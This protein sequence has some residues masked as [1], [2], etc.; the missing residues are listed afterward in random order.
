MHKLYDY[1]ENYCEDNRL[2]R[3]NSHKV[4]FITTISLLDKIIR[5][6][7][8]ILDVGAGTGRYSFYFGE[9]GYSVYALEFTPHNLGIIRD[10][11][12]VLEFRD[13]VEAAIGDGRDLSRFA[14]NRFDVVLC[15]GPMYHLHSDED[16]KLCINE[17][18]RVLKKDGILAVA[19]INK[20]A[21]YMYNVRLNKSFIKETS[22]KRIIELGCL[23][24]DGSDNF[25]FTSPQEMESMLSSFAI[26]FVVH[27]AADGVGHILKDIIDGLDEEEYQYWI[28]HH[29]A[30]CEEPSLLGY[31]LHGLLV[32]QK[33]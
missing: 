15:M 3:D 30:T 8:K 17:C 26:E 22:S 23:N 29:L 2:I 12:K 11:L 4:E 10:K 5:P 31:S 13:N 20:H 1:Y 7:S 9:K 14:D 19:Y 27:A 18:L 16:R 21:A 33:L 25:Y 32:C 6:N 24:G 28:E